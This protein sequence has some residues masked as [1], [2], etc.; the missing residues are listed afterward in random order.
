M[1]DWLELSMINRKK[2]PEKEYSFLSRE[3]IDRAK[4]LAREKKEKGIREETNGFVNT[5]EL[6]L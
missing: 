2:L 6:K 3:A 4:E 1:M 5:S